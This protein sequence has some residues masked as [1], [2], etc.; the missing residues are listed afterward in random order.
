MN[1]F[2]KFALIFLPNISYAQSI[3]NLND[4]FIYLSLIIKIYIIPL[5][6]G[7][8]LVAFI[9][10]IIKYVIST[11]ESEKKNAV[12]VIVYGIIFL[13]VMVSVWGLVVMLQRTF[14]VG[15]VSLPT[16]P[17]SIRSLRP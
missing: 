10:G 11:S 14:R 5:I 15:N 7:L 2:L 1:I 12:S 17:E 16:Q 9:W 8:G 3:G 13:F 4:F 6:I